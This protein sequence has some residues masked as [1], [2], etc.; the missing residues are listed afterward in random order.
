M[1]ASLPTQCILARYSHPNASLTSPNTFGAGSSSSSFWLC[2]A[3]KL[4]VS[5]VPRAKMSVL[6]YMK[7]ACAIAEPWLMTWYRAS[8]SSGCDVSKMLTRPSVLD[9]RRRVGRVGCKAREVMVSV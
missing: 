8:S 3:W 5:S 2:R 6:G 9:E 1:K 7:P 4:I